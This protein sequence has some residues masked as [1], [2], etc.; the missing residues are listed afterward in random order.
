[1][2]STVTQFTDHYLKLFYA[3]VLNHY[4]T[5]C[6]KKTNTIQSVYDELYQS[7]QFALED[8]DGGLY[9][10]GLNEKEK[11]YHT[12]DCLFKTLPLYCSADD[13]IRYWIY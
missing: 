9:P 10:L 1:M 6:L 13:L 8:V 2:T 3:Q 11:I 7:T 5:I 12:L 4:H